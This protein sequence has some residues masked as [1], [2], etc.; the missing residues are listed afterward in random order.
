[1]SDTSRG[2]D[3]PQGEG[4]WQASD[5]RWYAPELH[6][7]AR[8][9]ASPPPGET[10]PTTPP[11]TGT[12][13]R[14]TA[15]IP[16]PPAAGGQPP[17]AQPP[18]TPPGQP[19]ATQPS[20]PSGPPA[21]A[22]PSAP[23]GGQPPAQ[24]PSAPPGPA[25]GGGGAAAGP[26]E[27]RGRGRT[28]LLI[29]LVLLLIGG[30]FGIWALLGSDEAAAD[31]VRLQPIGET[32]EDP[33]TEPVA[34]EPAGSLLDFAARSDDAV[35]E[36]AA[37][38]ASYRA[39]D[40]AVPGIYGGTLN[41]AACDPDQLV[42]FLGADPER[43]QAW[44]DVHRIAPED[45][46]GY[47]SRLTPVHLGADTRVVDHLYRDGE[48]V[49]QQAVLQRGSAILADDRGTPRVDCYSGSPLT[50][51][52][53]LETETFV[54]AP[55][56]GFGAEQVIVVLGSPAQLDAFELTDVATGER[57][58]RP[59][60][61]RGE[62]DQAEDAEADD[63]DEGSATQ[64]LQ[65]DG[66]IDVNTDYE[67]QLLPERTEA[68]YQ[69]DAPDGAVMTLRVTN[70]RESQRRVRAT[71]TS[72]GETYAT[73]RTNPGAEESARIVLDHA[74][75]G[76]FELILDEGPAAF[77]Y[78]IELEVQQDAGQGVDAGD[79][80]DTA[81]DITNGQVVEGL[82][83]DRDRADLYL[84]D[85]EPGSVLRFDAEVDR[86]SER[87]ARFSLTLDGE[88]LYTNR[89][90]PGVDDETTVLLSGEDDGILEI[91]VDEG[92]AD[93]RFTVEFVPQED[94][95][96]EGD[97]GDTLADARPIETGEDLA[98][99][100]GG[101]DPA[102]WYLFEVP[103]AAFTLSVTIPA[104]AERRVRI[105]VQDA[106]GSVVATERVNPGASATL[107]LEGEPG[108]E[109]RLL[110]DEGR[111]TYEFRID[112]GGG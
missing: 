76:P 69:F 9:P 16:G 78:I 109:F 41:E 106:D 94:G 6:P 79:T 40:G 74:G 88:S 60:G 15:Y 13:G 67:D 2:S 28:I 52:E 91:L 90:N 22:P 50:D 92:P 75:G 84:I 63:E 30:A 48:A 104:D 72:E 18:A 14:E 47:V 21:A 7:S 4:W 68:R 61:S 83:A 43:A 65:E 39:P 98:G 10:P 11:A 23:G 81:L 1:V 108:E 33:F 89:V 38:V 54:G 77:T 110:M 20:A 29:L 85:V 82:L 42:A 111:A 27:K 36:D 3:Q 64:D 56:D 80:F 62:A 93:Y 19:D 49:A 8:P 53:P 102:D 37:Q 73:F 86:A 70:Q 31:E 26:P 24:P 58:T 57:F 107:E 112:G 5:G 97:A 96:V 103:D 35:P 99:E 32:G 101:R 55:W 59:V 105:S 44:A 95:G 51:P 17:S 87:R 45:I 66:P 100:V 12:S 34:P 46:S 71:V 25:G